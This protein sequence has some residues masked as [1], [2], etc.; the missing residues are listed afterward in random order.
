MRARA[1]ARKHQRANLRDKSPAIAASS[2][3]SRPIGYQYR[4]GRAIPRSVSFVP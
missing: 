2:F 3:G 1:R 4:D